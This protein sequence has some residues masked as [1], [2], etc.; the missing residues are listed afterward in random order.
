MKNNIILAILR[1][2]ETILFTLILLFGIFLRLWRLDSLPNGL[3]GDVRSTASN[4]LH[5][6]NDAEFKSLQ[7]NPIIGHPVAY[8]F[9]SM[10]LGAFL[11]GVFIN[12]FGNFEYGTLF[13]S[14]FIGMLSIPLVYFLTKKLT[15]IPVALIATFLFVTSPIHL[16]YSRSGFTHITAILPL[17][18]LSLYL[19]YKIVTTG[20]NKLFYLCGV[21]W[22]L[23]L[24]NS[25][26]IAYVVGPISVFFL[27]WTNRWKMLFSV[28]FIL[29]LFIAIVSFV[30]LSMGFAY[31]NGSTDLFIVPKENYYQWVVVR[32]NETTLGTTI[33]ANIKNGFKILFDK[34]IASYQFGVLKIFNYPLFH[35][36]VSAT[37]IIGLVVSVI[38]RRIADKLLVLWAFLGF[39]IISVVNVPQ[40][41]YFFVLLPVAYIISAE[42]IFYMFNIFLKR[43]S[44]FLRSSAIILLAVFLAAYTYNT[45]YQQ[46]FV[47]YAKNNANLTHGLG[48]GDVSDYLIKNFDPKTSL[49]IASM[50][51]P[52]VESMTNYRFERWV[53]WSEFLD[54]IQKLTLNFSST[55]AAKSLY[56]DHPIAS[57]NDRRID[58]F[59]YGKTPSEIYLSSKTPQA[60]SSIIAFYSTF[61]PGRASTGYVIEFLGESPD[62]WDTIAKE[63]NKQGM[64]GSYVSGLNIKT[65]QLKLTLSG[66]IAGDAL[67]KLEEIM[68]FSHPD[69]TQFIPR[70]VTD[71]V[72][73]LA[74]NPNFKYYGN[75]DDLAKIM[76]RQANVFFGGIDSKLRKTIF[77]SNGEVVYQIYSLKVKNIQL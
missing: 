75:Y 26:P 76:Y 62:H 22:G 11:I 3:D 8:L 54:E 68:L 52:G 58:T 36:V 7:N 27:I 47:A 13:S 28:E 43:K 34:S 9:W 73:V 31:I 17:V 55:T 38:R 51:L 30:L 44:L 46:Y 48:D 21:I 70:D 41:R 53:K 69:K 23:I 2:K 60:I 42:I 33:S 25:Y 10:P 72:L 1:K 29:G 71:V 15:N 12:L 56:P 39:V 37:L 45:T 77:G 35:S 65:N 74:L 6:F 50:D 16:V 32:I 19:L 40:E 63:E 59:W 14:A 57:I 18:I 20:N 4:S 66:T 5:I 64:D 49:I 24:F 67:Q 61:Q